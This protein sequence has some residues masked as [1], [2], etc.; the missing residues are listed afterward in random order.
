MQSGRDDAATPTRGI[1]TDDDDDIGGRDDV[2]D[3]DADDLDDSMKEM[4][5]VSIASERDNDSPDCK[6]SLQPLTQQVAGW[7][8]VL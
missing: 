5:N 7:V 2:V 8:T 1:D 6:F 4:L 3:T